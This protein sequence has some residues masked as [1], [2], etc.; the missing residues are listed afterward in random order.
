LYGVLLA[1]NLVLLVFVSKGMPGHVLWRWFG[2]P[3]ALTFVYIFTAFVFCA[4]HAIG[5]LADRPR[6]R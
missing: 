6:K 1:L 3:L 4:A 5:E 2:I